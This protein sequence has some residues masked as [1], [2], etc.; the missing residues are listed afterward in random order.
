MAA[1]NTTR[2]MAARPI[3]TSPAPSNAAPTSCWRRSS[4]A[5]TASRSR[6]PCKSARVHR[7]DYIGP[8]VADL[9]AGRGHGRHPRVR[10]EDRHRPARR[11]GRRSIWQPIIDRYRIAAT[12]VS[13]VVDPTFRFMTADWDGRIRMDCSSPYAMTRLI[14]MR[15]RVRRRLRQRY[16]RRP[17][18]H[19]GRAWR[20]DEPQPLSRRRHR[21][22][23]RQP[24]RLGPHPRSAR[25]SSAAA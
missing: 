3:P 15:G 5:S 22:P 20:A 6:A 16:G 18:R 11:R 17:A 24:P 14:G 4:P 8:Y 7:H 9:A 23:L 2:R 10:R 1:S 19:R 13:D 25:P 12:V 21:L